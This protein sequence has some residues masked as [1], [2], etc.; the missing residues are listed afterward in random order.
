[1]PY[2]FRNRGFVAVQKSDHTPCPSAEELLALVSESIAAAMSPLVKSATSSS[3][4]HSPAA[5]PTQVPRL[6][7]TYDSFRATS[8]SA[9]QRHA[10]ERAVEFS[11]GLSSMTY[12]GSGERVDI[13]KKE[14]RAQPVRPD[15]RPNLLI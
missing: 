8:E 11:D 14:R 15:D 3:P 7:D 13:V 1:M 5:E 10:R 9:A 12:G 2:F 6:V 4:R